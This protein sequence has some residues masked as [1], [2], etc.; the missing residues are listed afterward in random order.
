MSGPVARVFDCENCGRPVRPGKWPLAK[1]PGTIAYG[2]RGMCKTCYKHSVSDTSALPVDEQA[3]EARNLAYIER[4][5]NSF[6]ARRNAR[7]S[8]YRLAA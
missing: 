5:L 1:F 7:L 3:R 6:I 2:C 8:K 4:G